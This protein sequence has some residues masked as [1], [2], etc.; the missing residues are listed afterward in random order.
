VEHRCGQRKALDEVVR[1]SVSPNAVS[2]A[3]LRNLSTSGA[4]VQTAL[5][6]PLLAPLEMTLDVRPGSVAPTRLQAHVVRVTAD[7]VGI[8]WDEFAPDAVC[9][10]LRPTPQREDPRQ[11]DPRR[12]DPGQEDMGAA[13]ATNERARRR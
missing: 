5:H 1:L 8:E 9:A 11:G 10:L 4:F 3:R 7:G 13:A 2:V 12:E 6:P